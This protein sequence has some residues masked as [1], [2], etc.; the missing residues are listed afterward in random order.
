MTTR[1]SGIRAP[2]NNNNNNNSK[3]APTKNSNPPT[4]CVLEPLPEDR[5]DPES[6]AY[7]ARVLA[8]QPR[9]RTAY[10]ARVLAGLAKVQYS[11]LCQGPGRTGRKIELAEIKNWL[12]LLGVKQFVLLSKIFISKESRVHVLI[13]RNIFENTKLTDK[14]HSAQANTARSQRIAFSENPKVANTARSRNSYR[15]TLRGRLKLGRVCRHQFCLCR[16]LLSL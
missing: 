12:T 5:V 6:E 4:S 7:F 2:P 10:F 11:L 13:S 1:S 16:S 14:S 3:P 9:F 8:D 15:R